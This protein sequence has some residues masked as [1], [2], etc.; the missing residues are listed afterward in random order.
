M[1]KEWSGSATHLGIERPLA[2]STLGSSL[3]ALIDSVLLT[4]FLILISIGLNDLEKQA[5][6]KQIKH[7]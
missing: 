3:N 4:F 2:G 6:S 7:F 1:T 5:L